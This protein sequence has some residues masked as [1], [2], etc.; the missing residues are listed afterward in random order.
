MNASLA[1]LDIISNSVSEEERVKIRKDLEKY[2]E[3]DTEG[4]I[5]I[6]E[7][8]KELTR[9][10]IEITNLNAPRTKGAE[11]KELAESAEE[12]DM[13]YNLRI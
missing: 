12:K 9:T 13:N 2:C 7:K 1:F 11:D 8:L 10:G 4:M 6:V 3:L 5:R